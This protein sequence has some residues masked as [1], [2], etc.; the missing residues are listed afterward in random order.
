MIDYK[1]LHKDPK[2]EEISLLRC[3]LDYLI[4]PDHHISCRNGTV[5]TNKCDLCSYEVY[6][7]RWIKLKEVTRLA[8][9]KQDKEDFE[10]WK[11]AGRPKAN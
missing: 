10:A 7:E 6:K 5:S 2:D 8:Q 9:E 4:L 1:P 11:K 3:M